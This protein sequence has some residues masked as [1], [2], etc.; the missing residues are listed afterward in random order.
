M[1]NKIKT[2]T[3]LFI[4]ISISISICSQDWYKAPIGIPDMDGYHSIDLPNEV[5]ALSKRQDLLDLRIA[6]K[7]GKEIPFFVK[8]KMQQHEAS[9]FHPFDLLENTTVNGGNK[10]LIHNSLK[11]QIS[12]MLIASIAADV[13]CSIDVREATTKQIGIL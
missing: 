7:N 4:S 8:Q 5:V 12:Q 10:I 2:I 3:L 11:K 1:I 9:N 13:N 6:D